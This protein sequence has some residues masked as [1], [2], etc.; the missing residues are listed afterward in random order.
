MSFESGEFN[1]EQA[2]TGAAEQYDPWLCCRDCGK[3]VTRETWL[4]VRAGNAAHRFRNPA[5]EDFH[6]RC[7]SEA[8]GA[9]AIGEASDFF[10]WFPGYVWQMALCTGCQTHLG[11]RY[12]GDAGTFWGL[13]TDKLASSE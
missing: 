5:G 13:I 2:D 7:F 8:P 6:L 1:Q 3:R 10:S 12:L 11:W 9:T 4:V